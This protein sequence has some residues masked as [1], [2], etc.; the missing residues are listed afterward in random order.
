MAENLAFTE[1]TI[2]MMQSRSIGDGL[3]EI[4]CHDY[5]LSRKRI[6][7]DDNRALFFVEHPSAGWQVAVWMMPV[8]LMFE[9]RQARAA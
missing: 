8:A 6:V 9:P 1:R 7:W 4:A 2:K 3:H 5:L